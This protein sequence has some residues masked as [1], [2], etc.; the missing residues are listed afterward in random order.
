M[1]GV[2]HAFLWG[3]SCPPGYLL[4]AQRSPLVSPHRGAARV[5]ADSVYRS[6]VFHGFMGFHEREAGEPC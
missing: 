3:R 5:V 2:L 4:I 1:G 6:R